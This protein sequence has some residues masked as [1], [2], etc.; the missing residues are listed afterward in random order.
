MTWVAIGSPILLF[1]SSNSAVH[2]PS[3]MLF[4]AAIVNNSYAKI[5]TIGLFWAADC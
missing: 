2:G 4:L 5:D 3:V 1:Q